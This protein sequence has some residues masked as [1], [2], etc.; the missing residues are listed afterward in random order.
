MAQPPPAIT[1][2]D[3]DPARYLWFRANF[4]DHAEAR[5]SLTDSEKTNFLITYTTGK[6]K[7]GTPQWLSIGSAVLKQRF[8]QNPVTIEALKS[9]RVSGPKIRNGDC[10]A[11]L[12][13][14]D[15]LQN[16]C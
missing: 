12:A 14:S 3:G 8:G 4:R 7:E 15:K 10:A 16:C 6:A 5:A 2:F 13:L 11:L 9:S 1:S